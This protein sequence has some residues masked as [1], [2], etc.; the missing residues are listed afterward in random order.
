MTS[1]IHALN[2]TQNEER[3]TGLVILTYPT[4]MVKVKQN[5]MLTIWWLYIP[6]YS[7]KGYAIL[8]IGIFI[9]RNLVINSHRL[10]RIQRKKSF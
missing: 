1:N 3:N 9:T 8:K 5:K 7:T 2:F 4:V 6:T 10:N